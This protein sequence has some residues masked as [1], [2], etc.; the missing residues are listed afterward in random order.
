MISYC[1]T[2]YNEF[3]EISRLL[4]ILESSLEDNDQIVIIHTYRDESEKLSENYIKIEEICKKYSSLYYNFHFQNNFAD[5]K[6]Y[7]NSKVS[8]DQK[9]IFNFDADET[10]E[11]NMLQALRQFLLQADTDL[12]YLPRINIVEGITKEDIEK[13]SWRVNEHGWINWPDYQPR[14]YKNLSRIKWTSKVHEHLDGYLSHAAIEP[15]GNI[16]IT[17]IKN[18]NKQRQQNQFYKEL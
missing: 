12:F 1:V 8:S 13:W 14:I 5:L 3:Y 4:P 10:M 6:N 18:I 16:Y 7:M 17:H 15:D 9:Y 2:V 11:H